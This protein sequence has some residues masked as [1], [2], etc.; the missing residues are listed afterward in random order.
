[1][2]TAPK[3]LTSINLKHVHVWSTSGR[4]LTSRSLMPLSSSGVVI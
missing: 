1:L 4:S 3:Y 2:F